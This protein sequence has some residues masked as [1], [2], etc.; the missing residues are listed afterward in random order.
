MY[1]RIEAFGCLE[2]FYVTCNV[3]DHVEKRQPR[4]LF[5]PS[6]EERAKTASV[7]FFILFCWD[8]RVVLEDIRPCLIGIGSEPMG[9]SREDRQVS[10]FGN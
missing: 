3:A 10:I 2:A 1:G 7:I 5:L 9:E 4:H 6:R 8:C